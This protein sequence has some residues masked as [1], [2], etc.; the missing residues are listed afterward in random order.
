MPRSRRPDYG[1]WVSRRLVYLPLA[2]FAVFAVLAVLFYAFVI[3]AL[4][5]L[6]VSAYFA[7]AR[8]RFGPDGGD[9]QA[10][11]RALV[12]SNLEWDGKGTALDIG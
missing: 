12:V 3:L 4:V 10:K 8:F 5:F 6:A 7:Y 11:V 9:I 1:N 2:V